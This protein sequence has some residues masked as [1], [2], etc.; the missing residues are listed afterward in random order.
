LLSNRGDVLIGGQRA[1]IIGNVCMDMIMADVTEIK[2]V[3]LYDEVILIGK[4]GQEYI[5]ASEVADWMGTINYE[6]TSIISKRVPRYYH[7]SE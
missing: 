7:D 5:S 2:K 1:P 6:V 4:Q 3:D